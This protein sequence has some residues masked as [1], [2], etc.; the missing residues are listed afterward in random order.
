[1]LRFVFLTVCLFF[2]FVSSALA[3]SERLEVVEKEISKINRYIE[4]GNNSADLKR[5]LSD[6]ETERD[7]LVASGAG[8]NSKKK[9]KTGKRKSKGRSAQKESGRDGDKLIEGLSFNLGLVTD[10]IFRGITQTSHNFAVQG[11]ADW[12]FQNGFSL[13]T[14]VS[15]VTGGSEIDLYGGY[16]FSLGSAADAKLGVIFFYFPKAPTTNTLEFFVSVDL[17]PF[18]F[19]VNF[20]DDYL[21]TKSSSF[22]YSAG[23]SSVILEKYAMSLGVTIG[24]TTFS[25]KTLAGST[26]YVDFVLSLSKEAKY[27]TVALNWGDTNRSSFNSGTTVKLDDHSYW[28]SVKRGF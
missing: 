6:L 11:G 4:E 25:D 7:S 16:T 23:V 17:A 24:Y 13:G 1:M 19:G 21:G 5:L 3:S 8:K 20:T 27:F 2:T 18:V 14:W 22:Y 26:D 10:Y 15:N 9:S 12:D 28:L